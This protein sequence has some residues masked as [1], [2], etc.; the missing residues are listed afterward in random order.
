MQDLSG[1][2]LGQYE[3]RERLG[4]GGMAEVYKAYQPGMDRF[5]AVKV[6]LGH[7]ADDEGFITRFKREAQSVGKLRH[8]HIVNVFDFGVERDIYYMVMEYIEGDN[9]KH[10]IYKRNAIPPLEALHL[11]AQLASAL[12]YAHGKGMIHRDLKPANIMFMDK[13]YKHTVLTD[14]G[15]ARLMGQSGLTAS[16]AMVGTPAYISPEAARGE[17]VDERSDLYG[18]GI[19]LYEMVTGKVPYDADTPLAVIMKHINAPLPTARDFG[20]NVPPSVEKIIVKSLTKMPSDRYQSATEMKTAL[21]T[22]I[23]HWS[24]SFQPD[25]TTAPVT[26]YVEDD[27]RTMIDT[28][29]GA[30]TAQRTNLLSSE[31]TIP[32]ESKRGLPLMW[33]G[34]AVLLLL[35]ALAVGMIALGG[36]DDDESVAESDSTQPA[37]IVA[38]S[39]ESQAT[40]VAIVPSET[41]VVTESPTEIV[42]EVVTEAATEVE[43]TNTPTSEPTTAVPTE[44]PTN[45]PPT[46]VP[47]IAPT[48]VVEVAAADVVNVSD[49]VLTTFPRT[50]QLFPAPQN[51]F[52]A[53]THVFAPVEG[54]FQAAGLYVELENSS[55][56]EFALAYCDVANGEN[57][58]GRGIYLDYLNGPTF[59]NLV[60]HEKTAFEAEEVY[61]R[62]NRSGTTYRAE[63][64]ANENEDWQTLAS[65]D[66]PEQ[67]MSVGLVAQSFSGEAPDYNPNNLPPLDAVFYSFSLSPFVAETTAT[68]ETVAVETNLLS[69][70]LPLQ[71]EI[72]MLLLEGNDSE[73]W[74]RIIPLVETEPD[75]IEALFVS[76]SLH[77]RNGD[78]ESALQNAD[79]ILELEPDN[80]LG[81]IARA[82]VLTEVAQDYEGAAAALERANELSPQNPHVLWRLARVYWN[83]GRDGA[84]ELF[85]EAVSLGASGVGFTYFAGEYLYFERNYARAEPYLQAVHNSAMM[86][87][88]TLVYLTGTLIQLG[89]A[90]EAYQ[91][92]Q[93][94]PWGDEYWWGVQDSRDYAAL[95][96]VAYMAGEYEQARE[97]AQNSIALSDT[98]YAAQ[99][100]MG[101]ISWDADADLNTAMSYLDPLLSVE[102]FG[103]PFLTPEFGH[104]VRIDRA[105]I[106]AEAGQNEQ[107]I[108]AYTEAIEEGAL[109]EAALEQRADL[110]LT[111]GD[112]TSALNDLRQLFTILGYTNDAEIQA[113][114][115]RIKQRVVDLYWGDEAVAVANPPA[116]YQLTEAD[117]TIPVLSG[118]NPTLDEFEPLLLTPT[119]YETLDIVNARLDT[120][121]ENIELLAV[122]VL[123]HLQI[124]DVDSARADAVRII[125]IAPENPLGYLMHV[126]ISAH[127]SVDEPTVGMENALKAYELAPENPEVLW[128]L[129]LSY[130]LNGRREE[131]ATYFDQ[132]E[133]AGAK[134]HRYGSAAGT[135]WYDA[136]Q[137]DRAVEPLKTFYTVNP[138]S[139]YLGSHLLGALIQT[140]QTDFALQIAYSM[141]RYADNDRGTYMNLAYVAYRAGEYEQAKAWA[142]VAIAFASD[143]FPEARYLLALLKWYQEGDL[144]GAM[145]AFAALEEVYHAGFF[146]NM[147]YNHEINLDRARIYKEAGNYQAAI[148]VYT[149]AIEQNFSSNPTVYEERAD[150]YLLMEN[151]DAAREDLRRASELVNDETERERLF[152]RLLELGTEE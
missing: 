122:R 143:D 34:V 134:G 139:L 85:E 38:T 40:E 55:R 45:I 61:L 127:W 129:A 106:F 27:D 29:A 42:T 2:K 99:H 14:F 8:P 84:P 125:E 64:R 98:S 79:H 112:T 86:S 150:L 1:Q 63:F 12:E 119:P 7:L 20:R 77:V 102:Y 66:A 146:I 33:I 68:T 35:V 48:E 114:R 6:M 103:A 83:I 141:T 123:L 67:A 136:G 105:R 46:D 62:L 18:L 41:A 128:R 91:I 74:E 104:T 144:A 53:E 49:V 151:V 152:E 59:D 60:L 135:F 117:L 145:E 110:Y 4:R 131:A 132:A 94:F 54:D 87:D 57:C 15:I 24:D 10:Y 76:A 78:A 16:G 118:L 31:S 23:H 80:P 89:L 101:L 138:V 107:A 28:S 149:T 70:I 36:G 116:T 13:A 25:T 3:L 115:E 32:P 82:D 71:D 148:D 142:Q 133:Q 58:V 30:R 113:E 96:Y 47:T 75:N 137:Y 65:F 56:I 81:Y 39:T 22:A 5:V 51:D 52:T 120:E 26:S 72:D 88:Y 50:Q 121:P 111:M 100:V 11:T 69:G 21:D 95:A 140:G 126:Q 44:T 108:A 97:W 93:N 37:I 147:R 17:D 124:E 43:P 19:I 92:A 90:N 109:E 73:A 9:L 130:W